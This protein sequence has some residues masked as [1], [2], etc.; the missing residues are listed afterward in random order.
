M[1]HFECPDVFYVTLISEISIQFICTIRTKIGYCSCHYLCITYLNVTAFADSDL[2]V[3]FSRS[4]HNAAFYASVRPDLQI[5]IWHFVLVWVLLWRGTEVNP[6]CG[7]IKAINFLLIMSLCKPCLKFDVWPIF[8]NCLFFFLSIC[9]TFQ[10]SF[11]ISTNIWMSC[12]I[13]ICWRHWVLNKRS[14]CSTHLP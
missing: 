14:A 13:Q 6:M 9:V 12:G 11:L 5:R 2:E 3:R 8:C 4:V 1:T 10:T 7:N